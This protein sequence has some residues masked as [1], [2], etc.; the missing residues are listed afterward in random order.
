MKALICKAWGL[1]ETLIVEDIQDPVAGPGQVVIR[2]HA[3]GVNFPDALVIQNQ[4]QFTPALPFVPGSECAGVVESLGAGVEHVKPGDR[5]IAITESGAFAEK[6]RVA[7][8]ALI[9]LPEGV[10]FVTG[11][12]F[13]LTYGTAYHAL[14]DR[15]ALKT[16]E[17]LLVLG[18]SG[19]VGIAAIEI[20]KAVGARVIA[21]ASSPQ[22]R[23]IC[24]DHGADDVIDYAGDLKQSL[25]PLSGGRGVDVI[26]DPVGGPFTETALRNCAW[27]GRHLIIGFASGEIPRVPA[28]LALLKG[29][30][31]IGVFWGRYVKS[32]PAAWAADLRT[33]F[34]WLREGRLRPHVEK[35]YPLER[36]SEALAALL[37]RQVSGKLVITAVPQ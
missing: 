11:S 29:C 26:F 8:G 34:A 16:G 33:L 10:D 37:A 18:A 23:A 1:P 2:V 28:N 30:S 21:A 6:V 32:E 35:R 24:R 25:A 4:Y 20:G 9:P 15:A 36:G 12:A 14:T 22:K 3:A 31:L 17:T 19:G 13:L 7:A 5:V 27:R